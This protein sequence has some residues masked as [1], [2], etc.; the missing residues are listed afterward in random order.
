MIPRIDLLFRSKSNDE[1]G[2]YFWRHSDMH[3]F[4]HS[5]KKGGMTP[6]PQS[7]HLFTFIIKCVGG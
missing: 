2:N 4:V 5:K 1:H 3:A 6:I 7:N